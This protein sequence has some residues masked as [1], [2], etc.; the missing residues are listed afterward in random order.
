MSPKR[1]ITSR[2]TGSGSLLLPVYNKA[3]AKGNANVS[4]G[5]QSPPC[6]T[7]HTA[8]MWVGK[9]TVLIIKKKAGTGHRQGHLDSMSFQGGFG[10][11]WVKG[12]SIVTP[13]LDGEKV[14]GE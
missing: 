6:G 12:M 8:T 4:P 13:L 7:P 10:I 2:L 11:V 1:L 14:T 3:W 9:P 5:H